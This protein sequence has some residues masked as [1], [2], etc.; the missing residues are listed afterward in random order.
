MH[1]NKTAILLWGGINVFIS[2]TYA[3][4]CFAIHFNGLFLVYCF[5][6]GLS[7][8]SFAFFSQTK[9]YSAIRYLD[10]IPVRAV[11]TF[12]IVIACIFYLIWL[13]EV[14]PSIAGNTFPKNLVEYGTLT[15]PVHVL[16]LSIF[17]PAL[18]I[19]AV[20][21]LK[22]KPLGLLLAPAM[23]VFCS[24]MAISISVLI[25][26]MKLKGLE[27]DLS[28]TIVFGLLALISIVLLII[29][30]KSINNS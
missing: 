21:L 20:L 28:I 5:V 27:G 22:K 15:N 6:L 10:N 9:E 25:I 3:I 23:L 11:G 17:L 2:Y 7:F 12:L 13:K 18:I 14:I 29:F 30:L 1:I 8:Y 19:T 16:G 4:Y 26:I 24:L